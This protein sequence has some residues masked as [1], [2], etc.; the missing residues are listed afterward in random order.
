VPQQK[1]ALLPLVYTCKLNYLSRVS[2]WLHT[3]TYA[4]MPFRRDDE[5]VQEDIQMTR[6]ARILPRNVNLVPIII[7]DD[8]Q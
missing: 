8:L 3:R 4:V 7:V 2:F 1:I 5:V 6:M